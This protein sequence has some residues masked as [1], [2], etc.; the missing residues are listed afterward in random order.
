MG[1]LVLCLVC[2]LASVLD[3]PH[4]TCKVAFRLSERGNGSLLPFTGNWL[5]HCASRVVLLFII[6]AVGV[7]CFGVSAVALSGCSV[8][9]IG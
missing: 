9:S 3:G 8:I 4:V 2:M 1:G 6:A 5:L 7:W